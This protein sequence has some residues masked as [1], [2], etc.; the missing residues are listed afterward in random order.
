M[1]NLL[2]TNTFIVM[3]HLKLSIAIFLFILGGWVELC[4][5]TAYIAPVESELKLTDIVIHK[6]VRYG[7]V[8]D[9][10]DD[11]SSDR[12]LDL[13]LPLNNALKKL[14]VFVF[15]HGGG[16]RNGDKGVVAIQQLCSKIASKGFAVLSI[17]YRLTLKYK[18]YVGSGSVNMSKGLQPTR[19]FNEGAIIAL[20]NATEDTEMALKWIK[21]NAKS[22]N[23]ATG[24]VGVGGSSAGAMTAL[25]L[26]YISTQKIIPVKAVIDMWGGMANADLIKKN[27]PPVLI[28]HGD[29]DK[30]VHVDYAY[31]LKN[32][33]DKIG[34]EKSV[35]CIMKGQGHAQYDVILKEKV[36]EIITF[37]STNLK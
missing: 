8:P 5:Q 6:N 12:I 4:A 22:Y 19:K 31:A 20:N 3:K 32:Q 30:V 35:L 28:Y 26:A 27:A 18:T 23:F 17:N 21:N 13:Y 15:I 36:D 9:S 1:N 34:S 25:N 10:I 24:S 29:N 2:M 14:P 11:A 7:L 16:F 33:M 37:L